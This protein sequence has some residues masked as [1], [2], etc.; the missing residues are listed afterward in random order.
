MRVL[1]GKFAGLRLAGALLLLFFTGAAASV[2]A[3][4]DS[5]STPP[6]SITVVFD[7]NFPPYAMRDAAGKL[8]GIVKDRW[9]AWQR[10]TGIAVELRAMDWARA[11]QMMRDGEADVIDT[12]SRSP[13]RE[14]RYDFSASYADLDVMLFF[15]KSISGI[16]DAESSRGFM[17]GVKDGDICMDWLRA[18]G[19]YNFRQ[20]PSYEALAKAAAAEEVRVFCMNQLPAAYFLNLLGVEDSFR[21][22]PPMY[23]SHFHWAVGK[24]QGE[25]QQLIAAGFAAIPPGELAAIER[26][27][28][29]SL[30]ER[31]LP[32]YVR[33]AGYA[34][35]ALLLALGAL[36]TWNRQ[37]RRNV[38]AQTEELESTLAQLQQ[39]RQ[40]SEEARVRLAETIDAIP[41][42][43]FEVDVHGRYLEIH[44][45]REGLL[46]APRDSLLGRTVSEVLPA[47]AAAVCLAALAAAHEHGSDY[48]RVLK[49]PL[50]DQEHWFE[51]SV[52]RKQSG[53]GAE[54][55]FLVL[56]RDVSERQ[57]SRIALEQY[58]DRLE[59]EVERRTAELA[60]AMH[61]QQSL[62]E[63]VS[64]GI[65][66]LKDRRIQSNNRRLDEIFGYAPGEQ[67]GRSVRTWYPDDEAFNR[68]GREA[69][70]IIE[71]GE[72]DVREE[73]AVRKDGSRVWV[74]ISS[75]ALDVTDPGKG[76]VCVIEDITRERAAAD[77]LRLAYAEQQAIFDS[78]TSGICLLKD[79]VV[80][81]GNQKL[82]EIFGRPPGE[83]L[84]QT[85]RAWYADE[86]AW[87]AGGD[88]V[89]AQIW[90]GATHRREQQLLRR[91]GS[92]FWA[93]LSA[94]AVDANEPERG[95]VW[96][97]EDISAERALVDELRRAQALSEE[98]AQAK[99]NFLANMSHEIRTPMNAIIGI[100]HL[101]L[102][103]ELTTRQR[104]Y[105][106]KIQ[107]SS[108]HLL[109]I[110]NDILDVSKLEAGKMAVEHIGFTLE[111]VLDNVTGLIAEATAAK[112]LELMIDV[113]E[114]VPA[115]LVGDPLRIGQILVNFGTNA[116]KFTEKGEVT[117][118]ITVVESFADEVVLRFTVRDT[119]IGLSAEQRD[120]L[121]RS[122]E[123]ADTTTTRKYGGTGLGLSI[124]KRLAEL[125]G[126]EVGVD[127][128]PGVG[129]SF[130]FTAR[131]GRGE[132]A[133]ANLVPNPDLRGRRVLVIDDN[134]N[135]RAILGDL[136]QSMTFRVGSASS[137]RAGVAEI[138]R[139]AAAGA[140]YE[141][142]LLD[143]QM[144][145]QDGIATAREISR[146]PLDKAPHM[147][148]VTAYG[149][150]ELLKTARA[151]GIEDVLVKPVMAS[152]LFDAVMH[153][154]GRA[155]GEPTPGT[156]PAP[157]PATDMSAIAGARILLVEDNELNQEVAT[158]LLR[159]AGLRVD[160]AENGA[161]AVDKVRGNDYALVLMD[162]QMPV[163]DGVSAT[164]EIRKTHADLPIVAMTANAMASDR[165]RCLDAGMNDYLAKPIDTDA[166]WGK[167]L[168][169][170]KPLP[171]GSVVEA[172][173]SERP[174]EEAPTAAPDTAAGAALDE[175][176]GVDLRTGLRQAM[177]R[178]TLYLSLLRKYVAGQADFA[179]RM[180]AALADEDWATGERLAHTLKG[181]SAQIGATEVRSLAEGLERAVRQRQSAAELAALL[182]A[183]SER[184]AAQIEAIVAY[185]PVEAAPER[186]ASVDDEQVSAVFVKLGRGLADDD[187]AVGQLFDENEP[188]LRAALGERFA[189]LARTIGNYDF[190]IALTLL[191][192]AAAERGIT[193]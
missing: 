42:L 7:D 88:E 129:S 113:A 39:A 61:E 52:T 141:L 1:S 40:E 25:L 54:P 153:T 23:T 186:P 171:A 26:H 149:R 34:L 123:Q 133:A 27:W 73:E 8:Q 22:T 166:L 176:P 174:P 119:G 78:A 60:L 128:E 44:T 56:S 150:D 99:S 107:L 3:P 67:I 48:G 151:A 180:S 57:E 35:L 124:S 145:E 75:H 116:V 117:I 114:D 64:A 32:A 62:F 175:I 184:L 118:R 152:V 46:A 38:R 148:M 85:T 98:A 159:E 53:S 181:V 93:R 20:Y 158:E 96:I 157:V 70:A 132:A 103:T 5:A 146:L 10:Q 63:A 17:I 164:Q 138:V 160:L 144:P 94:R 66:L 55:H 4:A 21:H 102:K 147:L 120:R 190:A 81:R 163:M 136:L 71:R 162:M 95:S 29:G 13:E 18:R 134:E 167:L 87:Q 127:S 156:P 121:F 130:W 6:R 50:P 172:A 168:Q 9:Q 112:G 47:E 170:V 37:L 86:A 33:Y 11:Q 91:D 77:A 188:L 189:S 110:I 97:I 92:L 101:A 169:W 19:S 80:L 69:Y 173:A 155:G 41:D 89:Y 125:M 65:V 59:S 106:K 12:Y 36:L 185:L 82:H 43:L 109:G 143:W 72:I 161:I 79:R 30:V 31:T 105:L 122:F 137:G 76:T 139:A 74:R 187:F 182:D 49:L 135:S 177:G 140:P 178:E 131:L 165:Q 58:R 126:G 115:N 68:V 154:L 90:R 84:G 2:A 14:K 51:L 28:L 192:E 24:G 16:V 179:A 191:K 193:L 45:A 15:H 142:V 108:K 111:R 183:T 83:L 104:G 100:S